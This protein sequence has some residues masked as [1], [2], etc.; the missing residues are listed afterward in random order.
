MAAR[1]CRNNTG[2]PICRSSDPSQ[3]RETVPRLDA[4]PPLQGPRARLVRLPP[5]RT[6]RSEA[7]TTALGSETRAAKIMNPH[8]A[9]CHPGHEQN[10]EREYCTAESRPRLG[11]QGWAPWQSSDPASTVCDDRGH[12]A[13]RDGAQRKEDGKPKPP[14]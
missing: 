6:S 4:Q 11:G 14:E 12:A 13:H 9:T 5:E 7:P 8:G 1:I 10:A 2:A 3:W